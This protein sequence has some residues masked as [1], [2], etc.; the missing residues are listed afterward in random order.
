[1]PIRHPKA[2]PRC[3][4]IKHNNILK[5]DSYPRLSIFS[6]PRLSSQ[7]YSRQIDYHADRPKNRYTWVTAVT[8]E[9]PF[10]GARAMLLLGWE[11]RQAEGLS[12][13][14]DHLSLETS[15][16]T[17]DDLSGSFSSKDGRITCPLSRLA[18]RASDSIDAE[19][20]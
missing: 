5:H 4:S 16:A 6:P 1:M 3:L 11:G 8:T 12:L 2:H 9:R 20:T 13:Q 17:C 18:E 14:K 10:R 15:K 19:C 7:R